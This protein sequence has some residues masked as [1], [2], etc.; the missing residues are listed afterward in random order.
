MKYNLIYFFLFLSP[1][2]VFS[3]LDE[4]LVLGYGQIFDMTILLNQKINDSTFVSGTATIISHKNNFYILSASHVTEKMKADC[5][6]VFRT[7]NDKPGIVELRHLV[8]SDS[9][10][11]QNHPIADISILKLSPRDTNLIFRLKNYSF[12]SSN[13]LNKKTSPPISW[14]LSFFGFPIVDQNLDF[15]S[16][17]FFPCSASSGLITSIRADSKTKCNF[18]FLTIPSTQGSSGGGVFSGIAKAGIVIGP[19]YTILSG[20]V[21]GTFGDNTGGK[22]AQITPSYYIWDILE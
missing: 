10:K 19:G 20:I 1:S 21:H 15:F 14:D 16:P 9:I 2:F 17:L 11:W 6:A 7:E 22:L 13:I 8:S 5:K 12:P 4:N 3:Q 18:Y